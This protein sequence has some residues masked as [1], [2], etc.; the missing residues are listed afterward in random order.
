MQ[1][2]FNYTALMAHS[3]S[4]FVT[5]PDT[6]ES[7]WM[8]DFR[9]FTADLNITSHDMTSTLCLLS[10]S[11]TNA[12]PLPP[13]VRVP[14][15]MDLSERMEAVDPEVLS[16]KH[17]S[18]PC[19]AAFAVLEVASRLVTEEMGNIVKGVRNLVGEVDF[20]FQLLDKSETNSVM[21]KESGKGKVA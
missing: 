15:P 16:V 3:S 10:F 7:Q 5:E 6:E 14:R 13:Y 12:Q 8:A 19:Y 4:T 18:E 2:I 17:V 9:R 11:I 1:N 20:S 21:D